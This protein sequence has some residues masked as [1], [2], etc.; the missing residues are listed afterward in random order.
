[1]NIRPDRSPIKQ[2]QIIKKNRFKTLY[3]VQT[4]SIIIFYAYK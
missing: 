2:K 1:M 4:I 3:I